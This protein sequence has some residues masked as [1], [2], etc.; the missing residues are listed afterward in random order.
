[1]CIRDR[2]TAAPQ[3]LGRILS[4]VRELLRRRSLLIAAME[5]S[6]LRPALLALIP[7]ELQDGLPMAVRE[8]LA[9]LSK[10]PF[11]TFLSDVQQ[12]LS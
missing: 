5:Q 11:L 1:M 7:H 9:L 6:D 3:E 12:L 2:L 8:R 4:S 10:A